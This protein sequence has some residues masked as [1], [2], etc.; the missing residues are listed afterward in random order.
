MLV[1]ILEYRI[2]YFL[3][4]KYENYFLTNKIILNSY[5]K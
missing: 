1:V 2:I 5:Y 4:H 3:I